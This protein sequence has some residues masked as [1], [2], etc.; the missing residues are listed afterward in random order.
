M[1]AATGIYLPGRRNEGKTM[2]EARSTDSVDEEGQSGR[3]SHG[4]VSLAVL[5]AVLFAVPALESGG[6]EQVA[7]AVAAAVVLVGVVVLSRRLRELAAVARD[8]TQT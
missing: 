6:Y 8:S 2:S 3:P 4:V 5:F 1:N 7:V